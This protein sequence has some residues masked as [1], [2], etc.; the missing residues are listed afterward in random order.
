MLFSASKSLKIEYVL[1]EL[2]Q[3]SCSVKIVSHLRSGVIVIKVRIYFNAVIANLEY[4]IE[5]D[6]FFLDPVTYKTDLTTSAE[7]WFA[8]VPAEA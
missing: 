1:G 3:V 2:P 4:V 5:L 8:F 6:K 7:Q